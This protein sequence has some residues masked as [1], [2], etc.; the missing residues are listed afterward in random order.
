[1][2]GACPCCVPDV[3]LRALSSAFEFP[4]A[5]KTLRNQKTGEPFKKPD[6]KKAY[7]TLEKPFRYPTLDQQRTMIA[8]GLYKP[9]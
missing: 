7:I 5:G 3:R 1:M 4:R 2:R 6:Y 9:Q 8:G